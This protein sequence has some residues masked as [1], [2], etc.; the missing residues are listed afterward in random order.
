LKIVY[1]KRLYFDHL[2]FSLH[3]H[4]AAFVI[5][6]MTFPL[7]DLAN[8]YTSLM[9][10]QVVLLVYFLAY[11][12]IAMRR[13][14]QSNWL[15]VALKSTVVLIGYMMIVSVAIQNTSNFLIIAD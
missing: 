9:I 10:M 14:Y 12:V 3:L 8:R 1:L 7:E 6:A 2:I 15:A 13:V 4:S 11:L 5:L